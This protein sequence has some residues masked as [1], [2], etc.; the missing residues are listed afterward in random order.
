MKDIL[1]L[2]SEISKGH[3]TI[4][5]VLLFIFCAATILLWKSLENLVP[6]AILNILKIVRKFRQERRDVTRQEIE[7]REY[8]KNS[9]RVNWATCV[10]AVSKYHADFPVSDIYEPLRFNLS[11]EG[12]RLNSIKIERVLSE[13]RS[14][15]VVGNPGSGKS[16]LLNVLAISYAEDRAEDLF[17]LKESRLPIFLNFKEFTEAKP[18]PVVLSDILNE[19]GCNISVDF[20]ETQLKMGRCLILLDGLDETSE[21][22]RKMEIIPWIQ[23]MIAAY[24]QNRYVI[25]S[26]EAEWHER[27]VPGL[28]EIK[29]QELSW[30]Q[31]ISIITKWETLLKPSINHV[32][33]DSSNNQQCSLQHILEEKSNSEVRE[34]AKSPL[35]LTIMIIL[36]DNNISIPT[37]KHELYNNFIKILLTEWEETKNINLLKLGSASN[38]IENRLRYFAELS[39]FLLEN[40]FENIDLKNP[41][42]RKKCEDLLLEVNC[43]H[44]GHLKNF[45]NLINRRTGLISEISDTKFSFEVRGFLEFLA[46]Y[47]VTNY[48]PNY[49][50]LKHFEDESWFETISY[51]SAMIHEPESFFEDI[52]KISSLNECLPIEVIALGLLE[53]SQLSK[54]SKVE[55]LAFVE[56]K[57][58]LLVSNGTACHRLARILYELSPRKVKEILSGNFLSKNKQASNAAIA[59]LLRTNNKDF[60]N[61]V[62][63]E[64]ENISD[65][66]LIFISKELAN[67]NLEESVCFLWYLVDNMAANKEAINSLIEKGDRVVQSSIK[68][69]NHEYENETKFKAAV[70]ILCELKAPVALELLLKIRSNVS[71]HIAYYILEQIKSGF[72]PNRDMP[73]NVFEITTNTLYIRYIK[74]T[75]DLLLSI[76]FLIFVI[77]LILLCSILIKLES[78]GPIFFMQERVGKGK[79]HFKI[80][81]FRTMLVDA[82]KF[83]PIWTMSSDPRVTRFGSFMRKTRLDEL[84]L[85]FNVIKGDL[86]IVGPRPE[87]PMFFDSMSET[88]PFYDAKIIMKPGITGLAQI[89]YAY[90]ASLEDAHER[91]IYDLDYILRCSFFL[92]FK[93][94][95][96]TIYKT[97]TASY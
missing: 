96:K 14:F 48:Y 89:E 2:I 17:G 62:V 58:E 38:E 34:L 40:K 25:S 23:R 63:N 82:E 9:L 50:I 72:F 55:W 24:P 29:I 61:I 26:R 59:C 32:Y 54:D 28:P 44:Q 27:R 13:C 12:Q 85:Y 41:T 86:S 20:I 88:L 53:N 42:I 10:P 18:L 93:I 60:F 30:S 49:Q 73:N 52:A 51:V 94:I 15:A 1:S 90:G 16:T 39:L 83:G 36:N 80:L 79:K 91:L 5:W 84:P 65:E 76:T 45:F 37:R 21:Y 57:F 7:I 97:L 75:I 74:R 78:P 3:P 69:I 47:A 56:S 95:L 35:L 46:A 77:P 66:A 31:I 64:R 87:R 43:A 81:K 33:N 71:P 68:V 19:S 22:L 11:S 70:N 92:D 4:N 67:N 8:V 6:K